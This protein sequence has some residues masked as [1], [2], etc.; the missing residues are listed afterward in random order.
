M[1]PRVCLESQLSA[2]GD[3]EESQVTTDFAM[4]A[5]ELFQRLQ[6][7]QQTFGLAAPSSPLADLISTDELNKVASDSREAFGRV[8]TLLEKKVLEVR[9]QKKRQQVS[10]LH[11]CF[12]VGVPVHVD[13]GS[14]MRDSSSS[15]YGPV[16]FFMKWSA[17]RVP[18]KLSSFW[19]LHHLQTSM[20]WSI[21]LA[22]YKRVAIR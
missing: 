19:S 9:Q 4:A 8:T 6:E 22:E 1:Q 15:C 20:N 3:R 2:D 21:P 5:V 12:E 13:V 10:M 14:P 7:R 11:Q 18:H 16:I 17:E